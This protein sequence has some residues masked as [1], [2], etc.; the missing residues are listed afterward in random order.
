MNDNSKN[1]ESILLVQSTN[2][3]IELYKIRY[4]ELKA[5]QNLLIFLVFVTIIYFFT[6]SSL[7]IANT[8]SLEDIESYFLPFHDLDFVG[9]FVFALVEALTLISAELIVFGEPRFF[10]VFLNVGLTLIAA[11][12]FLIK[13]EYWEVP[14]HWIEFSAQIFLTS[15]DLVF[16]YTQ[17][18]DTKNPLYKY[19]YIEIILVIILLTSSIFKLLFY[20]NVISTGM[21]GEQLAHYLEFTGEMV[22]TIF[23]LTFILVLYGQNVK[24]IQNIVKEL[25]RD[26]Y[27]KLMMTNPDH[28]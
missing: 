12:L 17:F 23:A 11:V 21:D 2:K 9:S 10:L 4:D 3:T 27:D 14:S 5:K 20:G 6:T 26:E 16:I 28:E 13:P 15:I 8:R 22:N 25:F 1:K 7:L 19:R 24:N 18:K